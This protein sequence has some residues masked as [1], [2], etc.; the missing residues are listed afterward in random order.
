MKT[1]EEN[2]ESLIKKVQKSLPN[3]CKIQQW[4]EVIYHTD[5]NTRFTLFVF[6]P[7]RGNIRI[8]I[9]NTAYPHQKTLYDVYRVTPRNT[10]LLLTV[11]DAHELK[12]QLN[13]ETIIYLYADKDDVIYRSHRFKDVEYE[14]NFEDTSVGLYNFSGYHKYK[15]HVILDFLADFNITAVYRDEKYFFEDQHDHYFFAFEDDQFQLFLLPK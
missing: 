14:L 11:I 15:P 9:K 3:P 8:A 2:L 10:L 4:Y 7:S 12:E 13:S 1:V 6:V 5:E